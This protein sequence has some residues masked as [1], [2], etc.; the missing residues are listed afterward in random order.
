MKKRTRLTA[1][2]LSAVIMLPNGFAWA[3]DS[4]WA[5]EGTFG[6]DIATSGM[7]AKMMMSGSTAPKTE[8][9]GL[10][11]WTLTAESWY[12]NTMYINLSPG[13]VTSTGGRH[14]L[15][16]V[17][18]FDDSD[19]GW[20]Y[21]KYNSRDE[22]DVYTK[23]QKMT[24][25]KQ[26]KTASFVLESPTLADDL[27]GGDFGISTL[28]DN[29]Y[30]HSKVY[31]RGV[32]VKQLDE[33]KSAALELEMDAPGHIYF[34]GDEV[35]LKMKLK[36]KMPK[37]YSADIKLTLQNQY[38]E[39]A[40]EQTESVELTAMSSTEKE[41]TI[42]IDKFGV[43]KLFAEGTNAELGYR[44]SAQTDMSYIKLSPYMNDKF[45]TCNHFAWGQT[46]RD[47]AII[48]PLMR[49]A[50]IGWTRD[51]IKWENLERTKGEFRLMPHH[52]RFL[53]LA[54]ENGIKQLLIYY[55]GNSLYSP[56][57]NSVPV[58]DEELEAWGRFV[59]NLT[60][61][62]KGRVNDFEYWNEYDHYGQS[63]PG[64]DYEFYVKL[65]QVTY[66]NAKKANPDVNTIG[67]TA[68]GTGVRL[69]KTC[70][71][72]GGYQ[73]MDDVSYHTYAR[74]TP[75]E[76]K[77]GDD[78]MSIRELINQYPGG[79]NMR[80]W[81][82]EMGWTNGTK[83][84]FAGFYDKTE[85]AKLLPE[86][87]AIQLESGY[88][89]RMFWYDTIDDQDDPTYSEATFG[90]LE[91]FTPST[92]KVTY[93]A[94]PAFAATAA[95][96]AAFGTPDFVSKGTFADGKVNNYRYTRRQDGKDVAILWGE[97][98][99]SYITLKLG[100]DAK[101]Y[102][103]YGNEIEVRNNDGE[104]SFTVTDAPMYIV[105]T[106]ENYEEGSPKV[107]ISET[108]IK[109]AQEDDV[110][111]K[112]YKSFDKPL[113]IEASAAED[114]EIKIEAVPEFKEET[115]SIKMHV[116]GNAG[117]SEQVALKITDS[118]GREYYS[119]NV[120]VEYTEGL[121]VSGRTRLY[122]DTNIRRWRLQ[123]DINSDFHGDALRGKLKI[124]EPSAFA[125]KEYNLGMIKHGENE[126]MLH[127]PEVPEFT[128]YWLKADIELSNG[129]TQYFEI[130]IDFALAFRTKKAPEIDGK[131]SP[132]EWEQ[133]GK[134]V[135]NRADQIY[136][137]ISDP[138]WR[139]ANDLSAETY[140]MWDDDYFYLASKVTDDIHSC[141]YTGTHVW[142][143]DSVQFGIAYNRENSE[144]AANVFTEVGIA[145]TPEG[146]GLVKYSVESGTTMDMIESK[147][148]VTREGNVT[149][150]EICM[151]WSE[152]TPAGA[153]IKE[154]TEI[155]FSM[156][157]NDN[158]G[159]GRR[160]WIEFGSGIGL[161]KKVAEFA[162][163][164]LMP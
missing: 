58:S 51:E 31:I 84:S 45:G 69:I 48:Y 71:D 81:L 9:G 59:Y 101:F 125:G 56:T 85:T 135:S 33:V 1:A 77:V 86:E 10:D 22:K 18:Y 104:Y 92:R 40:H 137:L 95:M 127:L 146:T 156:I 6:S 53:T 138:K 61:L 17:D 88:V 80:I 78:T 117:Y 30:S 147:A 136:L 157:V 3:K 24:A 91:H 151:P 94:K 82:T 73:Y 115:A 43:Y 120:T 4:Q 63:T 90:M 60:Y 54:E 65:A 145:L 83:S 108:N 133:S 99:N 16:E 26:W 126:I 158:D 2:L 103:L 140:I 122:R 110:E 121:T 50:G 47:P 20:F 107:L 49:K 132:G 112:L 41:V 62:T 130:P 159:E 55:A 74:G 93:A 70:F 155:G 109:A 164:R 38:G 116:K 160:G 128:S 52:E 36:N 114:S 57:N 134:I 102:D 143:G 5:A 106:F 29:D 89:E 76:A 141:N 150:Y 66:E 98:K 75:T 119:G 19:D 8:K 37:N 68:A 124:K 162:R 39:I 28:M 21:I 118:D 148:A 163:I 154:N 35:K 15:V 12:D 139:G 153:V 7:S 161:N 113:K 23:K 96:N 149:T 152:A 46:Y 144:N 13:T 105:G 42:N 34:E 44:F 72:M 97:D 14:I 67:F 25:S 27:E 87:F 131:M 111:I 142:Q 129:Y 100:N 79:E 32:R 123:L 64:A 11:A